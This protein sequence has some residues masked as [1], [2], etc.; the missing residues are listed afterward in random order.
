MIT[1]KRKFDEFIF[2]DVLLNERQ[3]LL[4]EARR[5]RKRFATKAEFSYAFSGV[6]YVLEG[7]ESSATEKPRQWRLRVGFCSY[8]LSSRA[9]GVSPDGL[10]L[11]FI[12]ECKYVR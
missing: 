7:R 10:D 5:K 4:F 12:I 1:L 11:R 8:Y 9:H 6:Y 3:W 2:Q